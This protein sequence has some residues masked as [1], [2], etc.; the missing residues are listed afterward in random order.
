MYPEQQQPN[1]PQQYS[2]DYLNQIAPQSKKPGLNNR[3]FL[4]IIGGG[5]VLA[6][7]VGALT[8]F[9]SGN[10]GPTQKMETL[11]ARLKTLQTISDSAQVN[12]KSN[13]LRSTNSTLDILLTNANRDIVTPLSNNNVD[14][15]NLDK[16]ITAAEAGTALTQKLSDAKLNAIFDRTY[17]SEMNYQ[18]NTV[19]VLM[20]DIY[21]RVNSK[22]M[23]DF[24]NTTTTNLQ[25]IEKQL[26]SFDAATS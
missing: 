4:A 7:I 5:L 15:K 9:S 20:Q 21:T 19:F 3:L 10:N 6:L 1:Q 18:L 8:L 11:A 22:S 24:I 14:I 23:K 17:A 13:S 16:S 12:I 2:I 26:D 25:P